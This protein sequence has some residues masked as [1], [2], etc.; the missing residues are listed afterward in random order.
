MCKKYKKII[1]LYSSTRY[2]DSLRLVL[3]I[4]PQNLARAFI[5]IYFYFFFIIRLE[6]YTPHQ[7]KSVILI[8]FLKKSK[9]G[10]L[11]VNKSINYLTRTRNFRYFFNKIHR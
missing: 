9:R 11:S 1:F 10:K 6:I 3:Q 5:D 2:K 7:A 8:V 4:Q